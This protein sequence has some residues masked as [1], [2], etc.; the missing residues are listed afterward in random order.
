VSG[1][2]DFW[3]R[4]IFLYEEL[5]A[6]AER[7]AQT[8]DRERLLRLVQA[9]ALLASSKIHPGRYS[10]GRLERLA[11]AVGEAL[12]PGGRRRI[13]GSGACRSVVH[14]A[15]RL[16]SLGGHTRF[17]ERWI[18]M[19][20][21]RRHSLVITDQDRPIPEALTSGIER[22]RGALEIISP[23]HSIAQ[24]ARAVRAF[25]ERGDCVILHHHPN[26]VIP[27]LA[28]AA[29]DLPPVGV[30]NHADHLFWLGASIADVIICFRLWGQRLAEQRRAARATALL[31]I[32][33]AEPPALGR[34]EARRQLQISDGT[35]VLLSMGAAYKYRPA[36]KY[37][38][39]AT[40]KS[41]LAEHPRALLYL[42]GPTVE[43]C[44]AFAPEPI[45]RLI[46][47]GPVANPLPYQRAADVYLEGLP[48]ASLTATLESAALG[49]CPVLTY[50]ATPQ[51]ANSE[52]PGLAGLIENPASETEYR[53]EVRRL[54]ADA[55]ARS[56]LGEELQAQMQRH[57]QGAGWR[58]HLKG[59]YRAL[60]ATA[61]AP[62]AIADAPSLREP[63]D[64]GLI[65]FLEHQAGAAAAL[66]DLCAGDVALRDVLAMLRL[67]FQSRDSRLRMA[68]IRAWL[69]AAATRLRRKA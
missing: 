53:A 16:Y 42:I 19:D 56:H 21:D 67:S 20:A 17:L 5:L 66:A 52:G 59:A 25:A 9:I 1:A 33:L 49:L 22:S 64:D 34:V 60:A 43:E 68:D 45:D 28:F 7:V 44:R 38:F 18:A 37:D 4:S 31:P 24:K 11:F 6:R 62:E 39:F 46:A 51:L 41:I 15:T 50:D 55:A 61:H 2:D 48:W 27:L 63:E 26:D 32:P 54:L 8:D 47:L 40:A 12:A 10:D 36:L 35:Q 58:A 30:L 57:H 65:R 14:V 23:R 29:R 13:G 69:R 3:R